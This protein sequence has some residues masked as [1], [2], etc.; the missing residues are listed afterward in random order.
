MYLPFK[1]LDYDFSKRQRII[2]QFK[3]AQSH[4]AD[5][6]AFQA[7]IDVI[8]SS[9]AD[10]WLEGQSMTYSFGFWYAGEASI[11]NGIIEFRKIGTNLE[12][13]M[14]GYNYSNDA[15]SNDAEAIYELFDTSLKPDRG[16]YTTGFPT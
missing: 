7:D 2:I 9:T 3:E 16:T 5:I 10:G 6:P 11:D 1:I 4:L 8:L 14:H 12:F 15:A 13:R